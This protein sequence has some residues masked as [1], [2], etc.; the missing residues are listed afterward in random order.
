MKEATTAN[1]ISFLTVVFDTTIGATSAEQPTMSMVLNMFEPIT[2]PTA[3]SDVPFKAD[4]RLTKSSGADVPAA[5]IVRPITIS[6]TR[7][8]RAKDEAPS[9]RRSAPQSTR[10]T[11][12]I[13]YTIFSN[14]PYSISLINASIARRSFLVGRP[15]PLA[16]ST[17]PLIRFISSSSY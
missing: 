7:I 9:V 10:A 1:G 13:M 5:T 17:K 8:P 2:L 3:R 14:I 4:T 15:V 16:R 12:T 11:P 6:G